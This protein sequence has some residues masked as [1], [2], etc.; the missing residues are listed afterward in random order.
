MITELI[1]I[2]ETNEEKLLQEIDE[3]RHSL[4]KYRKAQ[5]AQ[6]GYL[7]KEIMQIKHDHE[8]WKNSI[9]KS[10][11]NMKLD[12]KIYYRDVIFLLQQFMIDTMKEMCP[13]DYKK[14]TL[15]QANE[16]LDKWCLTHFEINDKD[17]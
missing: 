13:K 14:I 6:I 16:F 10:K 7:R 15:E 3:L 11:E 8:D 4:D 5:F 1:P 2:E 12:D 9:C 17:S